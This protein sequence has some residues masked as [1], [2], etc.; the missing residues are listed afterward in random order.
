MELKTYL[1]VLIKQWW[2]VLPVFLITFAATTYLTLNQTP[3]YSST[4]TFVVAPSAIYEDARSSVAGLDT[5]SR[6]AEIASTYGEVASSHTVTQAALD[7]LELPPEQRRDLKIRGQLLSGTNILRI[8]VEAPD[9]A[10]ARD[11]ADAVGAETIEYAKTLYEAFTLVPLDEANLSKRP[12]KPAKRLN[13][14]LGGIF[15]LFLGAGL[16]FLA[17]YLRTP[18]DS[19]ISLSVLDSETGVYSKDFFLQRLDTEMARAKRQRYP[20]SMALLNIDQMGMIR[21]ARSAQAQS[22][23]LRKTA[24][25]LKHYLREEDLVAYFG[26]ATFALLLPDATG[27]AAQATL[28]RLQTRLT[29]TPIELE[30]SG[31]K[32]NLS[33]VFGVAAFD[34]DGMDRDELIRKA[35]QAMHNGGTN[36]DS[37]ADLA[38]EDQNRDLED[39]EE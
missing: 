38:T 15:G 22:E 24:A 16:G 35:S 33:S 25:L 39:P 14:A 32:V 27:E 9:P 7:K 13:I 12:I 17:D 8:T 5:L 30:R 26:D 37:R 10:I 31:L 6:R 21:G 1:R 4:A 34:P 23:I 3:I 18:L 28:E 20:L 29:W 11:V 2:I 36:R 19:I